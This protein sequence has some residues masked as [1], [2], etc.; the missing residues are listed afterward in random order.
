MSAPG[1]N[2]FSPAPRSTMQR[3]VSFALDSRIRSRTPIHI[4]LLSAFSLSARLSTITARSPW[5][6]SRTGSVMRRKLLENRD[7][8]VARSTIGN[9][10][11]LEYWKSSRSEGS[12]M[13]HVMHRGAISDLPE[14][15]GGDGCYLIDRT[16]KRYLD[17]SGG[18]AVSCLGHSHP[19]V[20]QAVQDQVARM[21][22]A[23]TSFFTNR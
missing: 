3:S 21:A 20:I 4:A 8:A 22:Y 16:G 5:R 7:R 9:I 10:P 17:A 18:A 6:S 1:L 2:A 15:V 14:A 23:H 13:S 12:S 19:R 11:T